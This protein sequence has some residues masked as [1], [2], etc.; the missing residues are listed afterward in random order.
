MCTHAPSRLLGA[1]LSLAVLVRRLRHA[2][3]SV[4]SEQPAG[5]PAIARHHRRKQ[6]RRAAS[7][8]TAL[9]EVARQ[10]KHAD[11]FGTGVESVKTFLTQDSE[12]TSGLVQCLELVSSHARGL[13]EH[14]SQKSLHAAGLGVM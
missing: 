5:P 6:R 12:G 11:P 7:G 10:I 4:T 14:P 13:E 3:E 8:H 2:R 1:G 9:Y